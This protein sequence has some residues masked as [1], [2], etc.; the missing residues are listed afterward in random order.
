VRN[1]L[2]DA[3]QSD[4]LVI[5]ARPL[6]GVVTNTSPLEVDMD[7][8]SGVPASRLRSYTPVLNDVVFM[9]GVDVDLII[10]GDI[11]SGG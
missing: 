8:S 2:K 5:P 4:D 10:L 11:I 6:V 3:L 1:A 7:G 9:I